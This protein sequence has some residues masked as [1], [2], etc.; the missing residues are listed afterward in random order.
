[1]RGSYSV[2]VFIIAF[3]FSTNVSRGQDDEKKEDNII[4]V[5]IVPGSLFGKKVEGDDLSY[6]VF[7]GIPYAEP[8]VGPLRFKDPVPKKPWKQPLNATEFGPEC[9]QRFPTEFPISGEEDCLTLNVYTPRIPNNNGKAPPKSSL[10]PV[11]VFIH[12][13]GFIFGAGSQYDGKLFM[14]RDVILV[15]MNYRLG[16]LGFLS[17]G[18]PFLSG[19]MGMK[20]QLQ[21]LRWVNHNIAAFGGNSEQVTLFGESAGSISAHL[22]QISPLGNGFYQGVLAMSGTGLFRNYALDKGICEKEGHRALQAVKCE[23]EN[24]VEEVEC[25]QELSMEDVIELLPGSDQILSDIE[26]EKT[27]ND[28]FVHIPCVDGY[29]QIPFMPE[30]PYR[31]LQSGRHKNLP[32]IHGTVENEGGSAVP[33]VY[34][35][36]DNLNA[37]WTY[38]GTKNMFQSKAGK[39]TQK[40]ELVANIT[41]KFYTG[42]NF[43][44]DNLQ[45]L[46]DFFTD[47]LFGSDTYKSLRLQSQTQSKPVFYYEATQKGSATLYD[48]LADEG[49]SPDNLDLGLIHADEL[50]FIFGSLFGMDGI[51]TDQDKA[52][53]DRMLTLFTNFAKHQDPTPFQVKQGRTFIS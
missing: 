33:E 18:N 20:D 12:G 27:G 1:M 4:D 51:V 24:P 17:L 26:A 9:P 37:N 49:S 34:Q 46:M 29:A 19:N 5:E 40:E 32:V 50:F 48:F 2:L 10:L 3:F 8:P 35:Q 45:G 43:T 42:S 15:T 16:A 13:G 30:L 6:F 23:K 36:L 28:S 39:A 41:K 11:M 47:S 14:D 25:L 44:Q 31:L 53:S 21:A 52:M 22:H 38:H 7:K